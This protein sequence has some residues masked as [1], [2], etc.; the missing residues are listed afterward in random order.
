[1]TAIKNY[2]NNAILLFGLRRR[3]KKVSTLILLLVIVG[4]ISLI[5]TAA[6]AFSVA[7]GSTYND[8]AGSGEV[9][10]LVTAGV[11]ATAI[12]FFSAVSAAGEISGEKSRQ[13]MDLLVCS[14]MTPAEIVRGKIFSSLAYSFLITFTLLPVY[15]M[16]SMFGGV[17]VWLV[18]SVFLMMFAFAIVISCVAIAASSLFRKSAVAVLISLLILSGLASWAL[19]AAG[20][21][22]MIVTLI[23]NN[24]WGYSIGIG[25]QIPTYLMTFSPFYF[26]YE[27]VVLC[28]DGWTELTYSSSLAE[29]LTGLIATPVGCFFTAFISLKIAKK[30]VDPL[31]QNPTKG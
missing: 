21:A 28:I 29:I 31:R 23:N 19:E 13:T 5:L 3:M 7:M 9:I 17:T 20:I 12:F 2:F 11:H 26:I 6:L 18:I 16:I 30:K 25:Y 14:Q 22:E 10:F 4:G 8:L 15:A 27:I 24:V 1:M